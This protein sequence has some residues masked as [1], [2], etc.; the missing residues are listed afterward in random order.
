MLGPY[1]GR[2]DKAW[3]SHLPPLRDQRRRPCPAFTQ[4]RQSRSSRQSATGRRRAPD[5]WDRLI[6]PWFRRRAD[7]VPWSVALRLGR[8]RPG[9]NARLAPVALSCMSCGSAAS[10]HIPG[11]SVL[12][13]T[14]RSRG[15]RAARTGWPPS[16]I[17]KAWQKLSPPRCSTRH[18]SC[19]HCSRLRHDRGRITF[20]SSSPALAWCASGWPD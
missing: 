12:V 6:M 20:M 8:Q 16:A 19:L 3:K 15:S 11:D 1:P 2:H 7:S 18:R 9:R 10:I 17:L 13:V 14:F 5:N 4:S